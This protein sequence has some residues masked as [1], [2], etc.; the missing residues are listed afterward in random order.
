MGD[1]ER[2]NSDEGKVRPPA[3]PSHDPQ[4]YQRDT[5][6]VVQLEIARSEDRTVVWINVDGVNWLR[7]K[8]APACEIVVAGFDTPYTEESERR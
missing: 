2:V 5:N 8:V 4:M 6:A 7:V 3:R 1:T